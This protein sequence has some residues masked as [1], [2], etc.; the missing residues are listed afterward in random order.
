MAQQSQLLYFLTSYI[1]IF[2]DPAVFLIT[3]VFIQKQ[4]CVLSA[5]QAVKGKYVTFMCRTDWRRKLTCDLSVPDTRGGQWKTSVDPGVD[6]PLGERARGGAQC[7]FQIR[8]YRSVG[9]KLQELKSQ[10]PADVKISP[11]PFALPLHSH[12][13]QNSRKLFPWLPLTS[14]QPIIALSSGWKVCGE[15]SDRQTRRN[16]LMFWRLTPPAGAHERT[17]D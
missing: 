7:L 6:G 4:G 5:S 11:P 17:R 16:R 8:M 12:T 14:I 9:I 1:Y 10:T 13:F 2:H 3:Q 15:T